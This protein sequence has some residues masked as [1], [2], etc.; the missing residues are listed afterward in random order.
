MRLLVAIA[1]ILALS[2]VARAEEP[3]APTLTPPSVPTPTTLAPRRALREMPTGLP[4]FGVPGEP[5]SKRP[6]T[7]K[8]LGDAP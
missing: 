3:T 5:P 4:G 2:V 7:E 6:A 8:P 1:T